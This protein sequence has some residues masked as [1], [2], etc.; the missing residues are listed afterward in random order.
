MPLTEESKSPV[1]K[2][3]RIG[4]RGA[5]GGLESFRSL[6]EHARLGKGLPQIRLS[7]WI[8]RIQRSRAPERA[9]GILGAALLQVSRPQVSE[10]QGR[11]GAQRGSF[12]Q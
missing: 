5:R 6:A 1:I 9:P 7:A 12:L 4:G 11:G 8:R 2:N 10:R 3:I